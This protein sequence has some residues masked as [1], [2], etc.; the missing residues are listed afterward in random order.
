MMLKQLRDDLISFQRSLR[1]D[2][3]RTQQRHGLD[4]AN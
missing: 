1:A 3:V 2:D 4:F